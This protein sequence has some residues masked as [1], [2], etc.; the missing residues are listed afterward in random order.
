MQETVKLQE[1]M[2]WVSRKIIIL[3]YW[4]YSRSGCISVRN[5]RGWSYNS[6]W[7]CALTLCIWQ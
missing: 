5:L 1:T 3:F 7:S 2:K 6:E 4:S